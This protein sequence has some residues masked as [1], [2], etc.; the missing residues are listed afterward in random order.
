MFQLYQTTSVRYNKTIKQ[1]IST[2]LNNFCKLLQ[3]IQSAAFNFIE[4]RVATKSQKIQIL[5]NNFCELQQHK[6]QISIYQ[7]S[8]VGHNNTSKQQIHACMLCR[9][10]TSCTITLFCRFF[11]SSLYFLFALSFWSIRK[12]AANRVHYYFIL[13]QEVILVRRIL[14]QN[15]L[16]FDAKR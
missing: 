1:Q 14:F 13:L 16:S 5:T 11:H 2:L 4:L 7:T 10:E 9:Y 12:S 8:F 6:H 15:H 3:C